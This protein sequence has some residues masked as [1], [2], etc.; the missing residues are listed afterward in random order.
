MYSLY[1]QTGVKLDMHISCMYADVCRPIPIAI[2]WVDI[3]RSG[4]GY[5]HIT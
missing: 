1:A 3:V 5:E 4:L 2:V